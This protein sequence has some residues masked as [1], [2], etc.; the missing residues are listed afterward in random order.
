[1]VDSQQDDTPGEHQFRRVWRR[2]ASGVCHAARRRVTSRQEG[3]ATRSPV[4]ITFATQI[5]TVTMLFPELMS[6]GSGRSGATRCRGAF[7]SADYRWPGHVA[8]THYG[9]VLDWRAIRSR[10]THAQ[11]GRRPNPGIAQYRR[12]GSALAEIDVLELSH[13]TLG[14]PARHCSESGSGDQA[15]K[16]RHGVKPSVQFSRITYSPP[17]LRGEACVRLHDRQITTTSSG[18]RYSSPRTPAR[19]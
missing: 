18:K 12:S 15:S 2:S 4:M 14:S 3:C 7:I 9:A 5:S 8:D 6:S 10:L 17:T 13:R 11:I 1:M 19:L 16:N